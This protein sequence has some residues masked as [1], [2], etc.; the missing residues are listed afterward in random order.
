M[1][2]NPSTPS[3]PFPRIISEE[4]V[5]AGTQQETGKGDGPLAFSMV[6][7]HAF[8]EDG[9]VTLRGDKIISGK[10]KSRH[11]TYVNTEQGR[12]V[13]R[14]LAWEVVQKSCQLSTG[15]TGP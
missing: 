10:E 13:C 7:S 6:A 11:V 5:I 9:V 2:E 8:G 14:P 15:V 1:D 4:S 12:E 3:P